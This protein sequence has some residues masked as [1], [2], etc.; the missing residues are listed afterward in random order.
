MK[1]NREVPRTGPLNIGN[2][3]DTTGSLTGDLY[4]QEII[5]LKMEKLGNRLTLLSILI[6]CVIS[7][8]LFFAYLD[9]KQRVSSVHDSGQTEVKV[10]SEDLEAKLNAMNVELA[11]VKLLLENTM[12]ETSK[13]LDAFKAEFAK[14]S[15]SRA[16]REKTETGFAALESRLDKL[17]NHYKEVVHI[18][19]RTNAQ[20]LAIVSETS[21]LLKERMA[22]VEDR[23]EADAASIVKQFEAIGKQFQTAMETNTANQ[24]SVR[25]TLD[26]Y[27]NEIATLRKDIS[28]TQKKTDDF[29]SRVIDQDGL[30][31]QLTLL[32]AIYDKKIDALHSRIEDLQ[33]GSGINRPVKPAG[34]SSSPGPG[35][36]KIP[37]IESISEKNIDQ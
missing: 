35:S 34:T 12:P 30:D 5:D 24:E 19:D 27:A 11:K 21:D 25:R 32:K 20:T 6:P 4:R 9:I 23:S 22:E 17:T 28:L 10:I 31:R 16:D 1:Q 29:I 13:Q 2:M 15:A 7:A 8:I 3:S 37:P 26:E 18:I 33:K 14:I 36:I